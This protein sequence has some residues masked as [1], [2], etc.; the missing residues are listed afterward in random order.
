MGADAGQGQAD[1][2]GTAAVNASL[3]GAIMLNAAPV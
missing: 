2:C 3:Y 1:A